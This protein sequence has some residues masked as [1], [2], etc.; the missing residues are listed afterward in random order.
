MS[1]LKLVLDIG[2]SLL[3]GGTGRVLEAGLGTL[4]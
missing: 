3:T 2:A 1:S 4:L